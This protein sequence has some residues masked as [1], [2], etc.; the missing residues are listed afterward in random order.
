[1][2]ITTIQPGTVFYNSLN[3]SYYRIIKQIDSTTFIADVWYDTDD[4]RYVFENFRIM[5]NDIDSMRKVY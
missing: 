5:K 1:M 3:G 2:S 4:D